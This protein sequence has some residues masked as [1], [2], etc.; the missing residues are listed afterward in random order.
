MAGVGIGFTIAALAMTAAGTG[1]SF[2]QAGK[3]NKLRKE[4][5]DEAAKSMEAARKI[6]ETNYLKGLSVGKP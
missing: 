4:A 1:M 3:Q 2:S 6:M 5:E